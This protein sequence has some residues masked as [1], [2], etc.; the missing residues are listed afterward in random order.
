[1]KYQKP[2]LHKLYFVICIDPADYQVS[3][4]VDK[5]YLVWPENKLLRVIDET[6][7]DYLYERDNFIEVSDADQLMEYLISKLE[8]RQL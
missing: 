7:E 1:M 6:G 5:V 2:E 3:L 4:I 8:R